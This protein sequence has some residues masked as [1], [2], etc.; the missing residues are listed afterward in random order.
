MFLLFAAAGRGRNNLEINL[1][2]KAHHHHHH[3]HITDYN[4]DS[5]QLN[6]EYVN[7]RPLTFDH[8]FFINVFPQNLGGKVHQYH[9]HE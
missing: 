5:P 2:G 3:H 8:N 9:H 7:L 4:I 1:G 6:R